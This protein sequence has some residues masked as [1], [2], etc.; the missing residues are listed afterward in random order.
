MINLLDNMVTGVTMQPAVQGVT[1]HFHSFTQLIA[2]C[3]FEI[4]RQEM[5]GP[6][7]VVLLVL[8]QHS[9]SLHKLVKVLRS[10]KLRIF[11]PC[12]LSWDKSCDIQWCLFKRDIAG[13]FVLLKLLCWKVVVLLRR[14][15]PAR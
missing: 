5:C 8:L 2:N 13:S 6:T 12:F 14:L 1:Y 4:F 7:P 15:T 3:N 9:I 10:R 11:L